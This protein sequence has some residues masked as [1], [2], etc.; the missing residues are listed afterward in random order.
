MQTTKQDWNVGEVVSVGFV[1]GLMVQG[2][3]QTGD[4]L[5]VSAKGVQYGFKRN[6]GLYRVDMFA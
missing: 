1:K 4:Y 5:L 6:G 2:R 3:D